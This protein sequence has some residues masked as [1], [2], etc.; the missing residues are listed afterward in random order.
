MSDAPPQADVALE[1]RNLTRRYGDLVAVDDLNLTVNAGDIYGFL[2]PNG[3]GKT[4]AM[5]CMVGLIGRDSGQVAIFGE[6]RLTR[7]RAW[8]GAIIEI[9]AFHGWTSAVANLRW[10]C[11]YAGLPRS[12]IVEGA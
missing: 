10:A 11:A 2:G 3:A 6:K 5:R 1:V 12:T 4:T 7:A 8:M 9:P